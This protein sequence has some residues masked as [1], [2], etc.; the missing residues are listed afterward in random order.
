MRLLVAILSI[1]IVFGSCSKAIEFDLP[2]VEQDVVLVGKIESGNYPIVFLSKTQGYF[3]P[4][5]AESIFGTSIH[6]AYVTMNDGVNEITLNELCS[7]DIPDSLL[8]LVSDITGIPEQNL[9]FFN[10][11]IY[12]SLNPLATG[13]EGR[14][15]S[16]YIE[17]DTDTLTASTILP[18]GV[19]L[20]NTR[21]EA[22]ESLDSLGFL[23][24]TLVDPPEEGNGYRWFAQ[25]I[26]TYKYNY[27]APYD[28]VIGVQKDAFPIA[29]FGSVFD[30]KFLNG[31]SLE[32]EYN[33]G[34]V[35]NLEGPDDEGPEE[36]YFKRGDTVVIK[37]TTID[38][39]TYLHL[40]ALEDQAATNG[41]PFASPGNLPSS[42]VGGIGLWAGYGVRLDTVIC[43]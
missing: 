10:Y 37:F 14:S 39:L 31:L 27:P 20:L 36:G 4:T 41:S 9:Q 3:E 32:I 2:E 7:T 8:P 15:Y 34:E 17:T 11:C 6:N 43:N 5:S 30:D 22:F 35:G 21:F 38:H 18:V 24:G 40:R 33:R 23:F 42:V 16:L 19:P 26:N 25:R 29:P 28:N 12:T 1:G 13:V